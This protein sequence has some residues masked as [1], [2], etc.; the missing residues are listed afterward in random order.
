MPPDL[1]MGSPADESSAAVLINDYVREVKSWRK[2]LRVAAEHRKMTCDM[3]VKKVEFGAGDWVWWTMWQRNYVGP[4]LITR[5]IS[6]VNYVIQKSRNA[7][8]IFVH[9]DKLK[10]CYGE[11]PRCWLSA[12]AATKSLQISQTWKVTFLAMSKCFNFGV[13]RYHRYWHSWQ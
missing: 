11:V 7:E 10:K 3:R 12:K 8:L 9:V 5:I 6:P 2:H 4:F 1:L 13:E